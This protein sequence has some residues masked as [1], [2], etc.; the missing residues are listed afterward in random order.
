MSRM[1]GPR[2]QDFFVSALTGVR[3]LAEDGMM[4]RTHAICM[5]SPGRF[6][7][8]MEMEKLIVSS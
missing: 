2:E 6:T 8:V 7:N 3:S 5:G 4:D 1:V